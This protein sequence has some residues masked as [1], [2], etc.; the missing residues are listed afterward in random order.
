MAATN[1]DLAEHDCFAHFG[2]IELYIVF[3][4]LKDFNLLA[5][6]ALIRRQRRIIALRVQQQ[7]LSASP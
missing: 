1:T 2:Y 6:Q 4:S 5:Y 7:G 3:G